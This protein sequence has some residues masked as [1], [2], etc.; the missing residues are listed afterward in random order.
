MALYLFSFEPFLEP[1]TLGVVDLGIIGASLFLI[2]D[3]FRI[4]GGGGSIF[5]PR[6]KS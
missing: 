6:I 1:P 2:G 4:F 3:L 5:H